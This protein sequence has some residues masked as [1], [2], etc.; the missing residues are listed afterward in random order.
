ML[1]LSGS[2]FIL[3]GIHLMF[4]IGTVMGTES[5]QTLFKF[6]II[7]KM[8]IYGVKPKL[9]DLKPMLSE[10]FR[11]KAHIISALGSNNAK[12]KQETEMI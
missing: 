5:L 9:E 10:F 4:L 2:F 6:L 12:Q 1:F 7:E 8:E 3:G 11:N